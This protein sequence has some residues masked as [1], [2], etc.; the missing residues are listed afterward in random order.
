MRAAAT[1]FAARLLQRA[2]RW[3]S[4]GGVHVVEEFG[5]LWI[6]DDMA[7]AFAGGAYYER[8]VR[9]WLSRLLEAYPSPVFYD[10]GAN[11]GY[12]AVL[13]ARSARHVYAFEPVTRSLR[14]LRGNLRRN[15]CRNVT[16]LPVGLS[17]EDTRATIHLYNSS[18]NNSLFRRQVPPTHPL[19]RIGSETIALARLDRLVESR[20]LLPPSVLKIDVEGAELPVL[21]GARGVLARHRPA[22]VVEYAETTSRD[23]GYAATEILQ[24]L[25]RHDYHIWGI[26]EDPGD[27]VL[28]P[29]ADWEAHPV[30]NLVAVPS[31]LGGRFP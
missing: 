18:G 17:A 30:A 1:G 11:Y 8:N 5:R 24:E 19:T 27:L 14:V 23:A 28:H 26:A 16:V 25:A 10:V 4:G 20:D 13:A 3:L 21:R 29:R 2:R 31:T 7:W 15:E 12:F 22:L 9:H 6:P